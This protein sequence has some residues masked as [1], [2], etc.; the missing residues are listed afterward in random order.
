[1]TLRYSRQM[2][3]KDRSGYMPGSWIGGKGLLNGTNVG[4][5]ET[6]VIT[7]D[8]VNEVRVGW[9]YINDGNSPLNTTQIDELNT[10]PGAVVQVGYPTVSMQ[11][12]SS[13]KAIRPLTTLPNPYVVWQNSM[14]YMDNISWH[15]GEH[16]FKFG[17]DFTSQRNSVGG[18]APPGGVKFSIDGHATV[19]SVSSK[20]PSNLTG[21]A[22]ALLG[23]VNTL[24]TYQ[25]GD[26][27]RL[28]QHAWSAFATDEWRITK[29]LSLSLGLRYEYTPNWNTGGNLTSNFDLNTGK[30]LVPNTTMSYL[31][32]V[33][34]LPNAAL[35]P[36]YQYV[37]PS[38]VYAH[39]DSID[40]A[41]RVGFA[42]SLT[43]QLIVRANY[44]FFYAPPTA[45]GVNNNTGSPFMLPGTDHRQHGDSSSS[46]EWLSRRWNLYHT[47]R[48]R[49]RAC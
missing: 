7:P 44:G 49:H 48:Q 19:A 14:Q 10:I 3:E 27:T 45:L 12:I 24:T 6:H 41:P 21:T 30:I 8:L 38:S 39:N 28:Y 4:V 33:V 20:R 26:K 37:S 15:K 18:G 29:K 32:N 42:Y 2:S 5:T 16:A 34:K 43:P 47:C 35:P 1:M 25:Y 36:N 31:Q 40:L 17:M 9:N 13:S 23:Y 22:E 46:V 11:N